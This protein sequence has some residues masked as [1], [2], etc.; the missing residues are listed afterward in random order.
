MNN[1]NHPLLKKIDF[2]HKRYSFY[3][4]EASKIARQI[5]FAEGAIFWALYFL[6]QNGTKAL[7]IAF[8]SVLLL[9]FI[10]DL[11]QY[12]VGAFF[13]SYEAKVIKKLMKSNKQDPSY[14]IG[15]F[16]GQSIKK[17]YVLK[18]IFLGVATLLLINMFIVFIN[19]SIPLSHCG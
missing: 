2:A 5:A 6:M 10:F 4:S 19:Y 15:D 16:V 11:I 7:I 8:Y 13:F 18:L 9:F 3:S 1:D 14:E 12:V 17:Y